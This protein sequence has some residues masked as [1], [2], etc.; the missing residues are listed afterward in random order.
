MTSRLSNVEARIG[1]AEQLLAV[2]TAMRGIAAARSHEAR[3]HLEGIRAYSESI[4][5]AISR[6]LP[7]LPSKTAISFGATEP[8]HAIIA[9]SAGQGFAGSFSERVLDATVAIMEED[10]QSRLLMIGD[11]GLMV[12]AERNVA[13]EW[14]APMVAHVAQIADL[15]S[16]IMETLYDRL[17][18]GELSRVTMV[19]TTLGEAGQL[20][21]LCRPLIPFDYRRFPPSRSAQPPLITLPAQRLVTQLAEEYVF[22][23]LCEALTLSFAAE[24]AARTRSMIAA[25]SNVGRTLDGLVS[26]SRQL[27][28]EEITNEI[29]E[30]SAGNV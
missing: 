7:L 8:G 29:I 12:A 4:G 25:K 26:L 13:V 19:Y 6:A 20:D 22:A 1:S 30:L 14:T 17:D 24:N 15:A 9:I 21:I 10:P 3:T 16:R 23:E 5:N 18:T 11:R 2:V 28:Q 27:R